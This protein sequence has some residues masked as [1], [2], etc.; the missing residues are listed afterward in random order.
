M[1]Y[2]GHNDGVDAESVIAFVDHRD[3]P[4]H[5]PQWFVRT[6]EFACVNPAPF[7]SE[8]LDISSGETVTFRYAVG[9]AHATASRAAETASLA[10]ATFAFPASELVDAETK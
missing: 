6:E 4:H 3:N 5:P 9:I 1:A 2:A 7:F 10:R 8:E